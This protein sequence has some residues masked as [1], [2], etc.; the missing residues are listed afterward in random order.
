M[1]FPVSNHDMRVV[2]FHTMATAVNIGIKYVQFTNELILGE[3]T[4]NDYCLYF[5]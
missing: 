3:Q 2:N 5:I 4:F 1:I